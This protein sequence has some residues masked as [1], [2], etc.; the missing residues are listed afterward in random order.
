MCVVDLKIIGDPQFIKQDDVLYNP[1]N[2][3]AG[4]QSAGESIP[5]DA[6]QIFVKLNFNTPVDYDQ[7]TGLVV[8]DSILSKSVFSGLFM[9]T[10]VESI[11]SNGKFEQ[12]LN[13]VRLFGQ[14]T[15]ASTSVSSNSNGRATHA[16][17]VATGARL[18]T[19]TP[20][21]ND[22]GDFQGPA[23]DEFAGVDDAVAAQSAQNFDE[24][25]GVDDATAAQNDALSISQNNGPPLPSNM[26][27]DSSPVTSNTILTGLNAPV[28][29]SVT[30]SFGP[31]MPTE[32][33]PGLSTIATPNVA[34]IPGITP[35]TTFGQ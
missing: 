16:P 32:S 20:D 33:Y 11:F 5:M 18:P 30:N 28:S 26:I 6:S 34:T 4:N 1:I 3:A 19:G 25:A 27:P 24:F 12:K 15:N 35:P 2:T 8:S 21:Y 22:A 10:E 23:F 7:E 31:S 9:V 17:T 29:T 14:D 13:L